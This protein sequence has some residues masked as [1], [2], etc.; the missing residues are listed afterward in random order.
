M[1]LLN[2]EDACVFIDSGK[3]SHIIPNKH[4]CNFVNADEQSYFH[5]FVTVRI[6]HIFGLLKN[7]P[8]K[9]L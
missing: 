3:T 9:C 2:Y 4:M 5:K 1:K 6:D 8:F 7:P